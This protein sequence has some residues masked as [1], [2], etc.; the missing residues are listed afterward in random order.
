MKEGCCCWW[1]TLLHVFV[2]DSSRFSRMAGRFVKSVQPAGFSK[3]R[4]VRKSR[5]L[6]CRDDEQV[7][8]RQSGS[9]RDD[10]PKPIDR[11]ARQGRQIVHSSLYQRG[12]ERQLV[13]G[14]NRDSV[15]LAWLS[16][17][18]GVPSLDGLVPG[19][20]SDKER[21]FLRFQPGGDEKPLELA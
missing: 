11:H 21:A 3:P 9:Y 4:A 2:V 8:L 16:R 17:E 1:T 18:R 6:Y 14:P 10:P 5:L 13:R 12:G 7:K 19:R 15:T 20:A